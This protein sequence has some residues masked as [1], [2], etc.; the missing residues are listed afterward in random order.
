[1][2]V[3]PFQNM[4]IYVLCLQYMQIYVLYLHLK[5]MTSYDLFTIH[6]PNPSIVGDT[7]AFKCIVSNLQITRLLNQCETKKGKI[8]KNKKKN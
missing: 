4:Q 5:K 6:E 7:P 1:M 3:C 2:N 8:K